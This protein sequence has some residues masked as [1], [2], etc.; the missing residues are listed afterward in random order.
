MFRIIEGS[1]KWCISE[2]SFIFGV[3]L[4]LFFYNK[5]AAV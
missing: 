5:A 3:Y 2:V 1:L 4:Y